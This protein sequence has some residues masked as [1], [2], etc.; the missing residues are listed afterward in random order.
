LKSIEND[1]DEFVGEEIQSDDLT[2][3]LLRR[4]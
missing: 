1:L 2:L 4:Q 3:L